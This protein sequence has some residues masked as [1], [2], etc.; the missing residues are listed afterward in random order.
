MGFLPLEEEEEEKFRGRGGRGLLRYPGGYWYWLA[1]LWRGVEVLFLLSLFLF[2][3]FLSRWH[4]R[5]GSLTMWDLDERVQTFRSTFE[6][7]EEELDPNRPQKRPVERWR[8]EEAAAATRWRSLWR[9]GHVSR[10]RTL[11]R[12]P[13]KVN[14]QS[15]HIFFLSL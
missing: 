4:T 7:E 6:E 8:L 2:L 9:A 13:G 1:G 14:V 5:Q 12:Q 10:E 15:M 11:C 3:V